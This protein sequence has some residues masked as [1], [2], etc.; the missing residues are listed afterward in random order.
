MAGDRSRRTEPDGLDI[1]KLDRYGHPCNEF[2]TMSS[3]FV[4]VTTTRLIDSGAYPEL[5]QIWDY[6]S[7]YVDRERIPRLRDEVV[8]LVAEL[9][10]SMATEAFSASAVLSDLDELLTLLREAVD[11][12][13]GIL[14]EGP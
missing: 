8:A 3:A 14:A 13:V 1:Y 6:K 7:T 5:R 2:I 10:S 9:P 12:G 4:S 11:A